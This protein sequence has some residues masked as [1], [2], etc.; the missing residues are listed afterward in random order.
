MEVKEEMFTNMEVLE[1]MFTNMEVLEEM[2]T[3]MEVIE[4]IFTNL[5]K[6]VAALKADYTHTYVVF[7]YTFLTSR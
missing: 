5:E 1:E 4:E 6:P 7:K 3:N 2:F